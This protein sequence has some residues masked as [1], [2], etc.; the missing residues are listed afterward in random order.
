MVRPKSRNAILLCAVLGTCEECKKVWCLQQKI[1]SYRTSPIFH[2]LL[3]FRVSLD[4]AYHRHIL[5]ILIF[6]LSYCTCNLEAHA[7][8]HN[9]W[10]VHRLFFLRFRQ[11]ASLNARLY[12]SARNRLSCCI[13]SCS[14]IFVPFLF[15]FFTELTLL[16]RFTGIVPYDSKN[17]NTSCF[18]NPFL[19]GVYKTH[20]LFKTVSCPSITSRK[21]HTCVMYRYIL[22]VL[23]GMLQDGYGGIHGAKYIGFSCC[24][25]SH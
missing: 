15:F 17:S 12:F 13:E 14:H 16:P 4:I 10:V 11:D 23:H 7:Q 1:L 3:L 5:L 2:Y 19:F 22:Y 8:G 24:Q 18:S 6:L 21:M 20:I 25:L 9:F